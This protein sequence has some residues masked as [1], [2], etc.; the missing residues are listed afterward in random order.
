MST[1][2]PN[3]TIYCYMLFIKHIMRSKWQLEVDSFI[4]WKYEAI[5]RA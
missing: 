3:T 1:H 5:D 4:K 2:E